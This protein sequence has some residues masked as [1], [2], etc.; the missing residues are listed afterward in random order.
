MSTL[1]LLVLFLAPP[2][3]PCTPSFAPAGAVIRD[4][5]TADG[6]DELIAAGRKLFAEG[7][8]EEALAVFESAEQQDKGSL[9]TRV[10]VLRT[11]IAQGRIEEALGET[12]VLK[13]TFKSGVEIDYLYGMGF[14]AMATRDV[15]E[16]NTTS[17]TGSQFEDAVAMLTKVGAA[18]DPRFE[19][20]WVALAEAAWNAGNSDVGRQASEKAIELSPN[21]PWRRLLRGKLALSAYTTLRADESQAS[22]AEAQW[23]TALAAF[24]KAAQLCGENPQGDLLR[25]ASQ[26][27][28]QL[29]TVY[30]WKQQTPDA[31]A[32][33][34]KAI[35]LDPNLVDY[36]AIS[37]ALDP[38]AFLETLEA[39]HKSWST[40]HPAPGAD[41]AALVWWIGY[42]NYALKK[43]PQSEQA[44][45]SALAKNPAFTNA[46]YY[47]FRVRYDK[48]EFAKCMQ[49]LHAY[50]DQDNAGLIASLAY[51]V[52]GNTARMEF[53][54]GWSV[55]PENHDGKV[56]NLEAA[57]LCELITQ[58][59][60]RE[61]E[62]SRHWNNLGLFLRDEGDA[63]RGTQ[64][65]LRP[66]PKPYDEAKVNKLWEDALAAYEV[67][68]ELEPKNPNY[69]NDTAVMLHYYLLR[70]LERA[71]Q[72]YEQGLVEAT[73]LLKRTDLT[74][75]RR[76]E[77][78]IAERDNRN[79]I[80]LVQTL[81]DKRAAEAAASKG[82]K[83]AGQ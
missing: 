19:D 11:W 77:V 75:T 76:D 31:S 3:L 28:S 63:I 66:A 4:A 58:I 6:I 74:P 54:V 25:A 73:A 43:F 57:F 46:L 50:N 17:V 39:A 53:L 69:L 62:N 61:P 68:L 79:N 55:T 13:A 5:S 2:L 83:P 70:D 48:Q 12:D 20:A 37:A 82:D 14:Y 59:V 21:D 26:A 34:A 36:A 10:F 80:R 38:Q 47:L 30:L 81:I 16:G 32:A 27:Q 8:L 22:A 72:M 60:P 1:P 65:A 45:E 23:Q 64:G 49:T 29:A 67:S 52:V 44:F 40:K 33:Y 15:A 71:K 35:A 9:R 41:D 42:A 51:D 56:Q 78:K 7:K 18:N 24:Q